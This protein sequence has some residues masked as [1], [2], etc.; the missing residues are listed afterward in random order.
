[1][2]SR[3]EE[4]AKSL[5][6]ETS[7]KTRCRHFS[8]ILYKRKIIS[9]GMNCKKT[10]PINLLNPKFC[11]ENGLNVSDQKQI[12]SELNSILK[13]KRMTNIDT[14]K[15]ILVNLRYDKNGNLA[16]S[17]PC[18]SCENLLKYHNFKKIIWTNDNGEYVSL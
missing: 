9:I 3:L 11:K 8:F 4:I 12:C 1:M 7:F 15:C 6:D 13:L 18:S 10:H 5:I 17:K 14:N 2:F 16:L